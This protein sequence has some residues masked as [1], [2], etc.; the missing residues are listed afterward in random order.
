[1]ID[2]EAMGVRGDPDDPF[3]LG[4]V[5]LLEHDPDLGAALGE[6]E[7]AQARRHCL[8][9]ALHLPRGELG[10]LP[11]AG[12]DPRGYEVLSG[13]MSRTVLLDHRRSAEILG[14]GDVLFPRPLPGERTIAPTQRWRV[15]EEALLAVLDT[16]FD[17]YA[18][19]WPELNGALLQ[20]SLQRS[21]SLMLRLAIAKTRIIARRVMLLLWHF[22]DRWGRVGP[23]GTHLPLVLTRTILADLVCSTRETVS[24]ALKDLERFDLVQALDDGFLLRG[25]SPAELHAAL[26]SA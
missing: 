18:R 3:H 26:D 13:F 2:V 21:S 24:R 20:R 14:P 11:D 16:R 22:A 17:T 25:K 6:T 10:A 5:A 8:V 4:S 12:R 1:V 9:T 15:H 19:R 23:R 7:F